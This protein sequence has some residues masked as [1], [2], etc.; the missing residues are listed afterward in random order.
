MVA[1]EDTLEVAED[2]AVVVTVDVALVEMVVAVVETVLDC[3]DVADVVIVVTS[4]PKMV[5]AKYASTALPSA[6]TASTPSA[7]DPSIYKCL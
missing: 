6:A 5:P 7:S 2:E 1:V 3:V 4:H